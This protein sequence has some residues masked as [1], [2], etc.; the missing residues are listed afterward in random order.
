MSILRVELVL[1]NIVRRHS[2]V[3]ANIIADGVIGTKLSLIK[4]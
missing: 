3:T 4:N 1:T 2:A